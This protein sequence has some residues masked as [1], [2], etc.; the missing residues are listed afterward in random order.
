MN[1]QPVLA[2]KKI[3]QECSEQCGKGVICIPY[4]KRL[5][6]GITNEQINDTFTSII[7]E[8]LSNMKKKAYTNEWLIYELENYFSSQPLPV[9]LAKAFI[10]SLFDSI[11]KNNIDINFKMI[12]KG[13]PK[14]LSKNDRDLTLGSIILFLFYLDNYVSI[15]GIDC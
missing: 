9:E 2:V 15:E 4:F 13:M 8:N 5:K 14:W 1:N 3:L 10:V 6:Q 7:Q 12:S 11:S